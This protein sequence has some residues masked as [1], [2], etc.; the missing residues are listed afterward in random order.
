TSLFILSATNT[1]MSHPFDSLTKSHSLSINE[2][3]SN[4]LVYVRL[5]KK[6]NFRSNSESKQRDFSQAKSRHSVVIRFFPEMVKVSDT[7]LPP[8]LW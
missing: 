4:R 1:T 6:E 8:I 5:R 2:D 3:S 7:A